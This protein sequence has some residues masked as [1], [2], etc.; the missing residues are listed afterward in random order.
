MFLLV[1]DGT[2]RGNKW[3]DNA[4]C[5]GI[6]GLSCSLHVNQRRPDVLLHICYTSGPLMWPPGPFRLNL[7]G[8]S[9][10]LLR[11]VPFFFL[12]IP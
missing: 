6:W 12:L 9:R 7:H 10:D 1:Q 11:I 8:V 3:Q 5:A 2:L 4:A